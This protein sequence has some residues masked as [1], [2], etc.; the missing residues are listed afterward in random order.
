MSYSQN[1]EE[2]IILSHFGEKI[3]SF[4]DIGAHDGKEYSNTLALAERGWTGVC[5]EPSP[6]SFVKLL[7]LHGANPKIT[8]VQA[9]LVPG[10]GK[11]CSFYDSCGSTVSSLDHA[12][13]KKWEAGYGSKFRLMHLFAVGVQHFFLRYGT[14]FDFVNLD[15]EG[16]NL[17]LFFAL[18]LGQLTKLKLLCV[19]HD[20][21][22]D[23]MERRA[24]EYGFRPISRNGE[25]LLLWR[26]LPVRIEA[27]A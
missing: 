21:Q 2:E 25:N 11:W 22:W 5:V 27:Q 10:A 17:D 1:N 12:H 23:L 26:D 16:T 6:E 4:L 14:D 13:T 8:C 20:S 9:A 19:E 7:A 3:G 18:P 24:A 15:V